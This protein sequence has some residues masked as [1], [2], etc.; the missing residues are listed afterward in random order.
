[1]ADGEYTKKQAAAA[2]GVTVPR[3]QA[4]IRQGRLTTRREQ[5]TRGDVIYIPIA[6]VEAIKAA[7]RK[8]GWKAGQ[9]RPRKP[10]SEVGPA[11][12]KR[13]EKARLAEV[14]DGPASEPTP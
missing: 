11:Q 3:I 5:E 12:R 1:M 8:P 2:L 4:L 6:E 14:T 7:P 9:P 13:R 10:E